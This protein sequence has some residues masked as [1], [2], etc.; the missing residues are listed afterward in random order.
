[1]GD[2]YFEAI[3][4][5]TAD[6][7]WEV[8][9]EGRIVSCNDQCIKIYGYTRG[10]ICQMSVAEFEAKRD[11]VQ[12][13]A[14]IREILEVGH[15]RFETRHRCK[16]G[17]VIDVEVSTTYHREKGRFLT[18]LRDI[19]ERRRAEA[20]LRESEERY[21]AVVESFFN[22]CV[23]HQDGKIV[24]ANSAFAAT[25]GYRS[26]EIIGQPISLFFDPEGDDETAGVEK[27]S[28]VVSGRRKDGS[29]VPVE[30]AGCPCMLR[31]RP[32]RIKVVHDLSEQQ[33]AEKERE[34]LKAQLAHAQKM[35]SV[36]CLAGGIAHDLNNILSPIVTIASL[37]REKQIAQQECDL[38]DIVKSSAM[39]GAE[40]IHQ[41]LVFSRQQKG[42]K[43]VIEPQ[44]VIAE[45]VALMRET[46]PREIQIQVGV[47][48]DLWSIEAVAS[49]LHQV[50]LNLCVNA[51]DAMPSGG[52]LRI[53]ANNRS[54]NE[55][56]AKSVSLPGGSY[57]V[58]SVAD[59]G[60]GIPP[61]VRD[62]IFDPFFTTKPLGKGTGLGLSTVLGI[63]KEHGGTVTISSVP[64]RGTEFYV[65]LPA[66]VGSSARAAEKT[67]S[68]RVAPAGE[69]AAG[70]MVLIVDD[71][72]NI[73]HAMRLLLE[74]KGYQVCA[75]PNGV[76]A[77]RKFLEVRDK[78]GAVVTDMMM[79][80]MGGI[81]F[82]R[83]LRA[84]DDSVPV[85]VMSGLTEAIPP[86]VVVELAVDRVLMKPVEPAL[87]LDAVGRRSRLSQTRSAIVPDA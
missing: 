14:H 10:E 59:T 20:E 76:E 62:R 31:S 37:L 16:D 17:S 43:L 39:R 71:E 29:S 22:G 45:T 85:I 47:E 69:D 72:P 49:Q 67:A 48:R 27:L 74:S 19:T 58:L 35:E 51:R 36:G 57:I 13:A 28:K 55:E 38:L 25:F 50:M 18:F 66:L 73:L 64:G 78:L 68:P 23:V 81:T 60:H 40:I 77:L 82:L 5:T 26:D 63:V 41:L 56:E 34:W 32:A 15:A 70:R 65:Y 3:T 12:T 75:A 42:E 30:V 33:R 6:G 83:A 9:S 8:N 87:L 46:F 86:E 7:Y 54:L 11:P 53:A 80:V 2:S 44:F 4:A 79:P 21:H 1:M 24:V 52:M 84:I 61:E